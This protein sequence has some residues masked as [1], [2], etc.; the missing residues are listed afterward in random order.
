M[1]ERGE[2]SGPGTEKET[3]PLGRLESILGYRFNNRQ[4]LE[5]SLTHPTYA[6]EHPDPNLKDNQ[7]LEFLGDA[8]LNLVVGHLLM[9][10]FPDAREGELTRM[11][12]NLVNESGLSEQARGLGLGAYIRLGA[13]EMATHGREKS[14][15]LADTLEAVMAAIYLDG[16]SEKAFMI[17]R[18]LFSP[19]LGN[20]KADV[21]TDLQ[22]LVQ[23]KL[24]II[25]TYRVLGETGPAHEKT[26]T[27]ELSAGDTTTIGVGKSKKLAEKSAAEKALKQ[28]SNRER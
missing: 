14:S 26:F 27:V 2:K 22:E 5:K 21:K 25:P 23:K 8:V 1:N 10:H 6:H 12:A 9:Q 15:I 24:G 3:L 11:R 13:G 4:L 16:G 19:L 7:R 28:L 20:P 18:K 17:I